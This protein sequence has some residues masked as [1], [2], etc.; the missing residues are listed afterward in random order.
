MNINLN[1]LKAEMLII[2]NCLPSNY[3]HDVTKGICKESTFPNVY[4]MLQVAL[5]IPVS[6]ATCERSFSSM[7][8]LKNWLRA[9]MEQQ[10]FTDLSILNIERDVVNKITSSEILKKYS[11]SNRKII[12]V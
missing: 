8:R 12:L 9:S 1:L 6:S 4:K 7:R 2:K 10:R 3:N 5:T 11:T